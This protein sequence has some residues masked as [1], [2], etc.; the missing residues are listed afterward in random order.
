[1]RAIVLTERAQ[2]FILEFVSTLILGLVTFATV[3]DRERNMS[4]NAAPLVTPP[5]FFSV[6]GRSV[7]RK[8]R[9]GGAEGRA[10][11]AACALRLR[12]ARAGCTCV[13]AV[14]C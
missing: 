3:V 7:R 6:P 14:P 5:L 2:V 11:P 12:T 10:I 9:S 4:D 13:S 8:R 1:M